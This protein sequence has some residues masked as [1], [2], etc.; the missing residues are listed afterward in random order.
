[1]QKRPFEI[2]SKTRWSKTAI[3]LLGGNGVGPAMNQFAD[4]NDMFVD[5]HNALYVADSLNHRIVKWDEDTHQA[6]IVAGGNGK[7]GQKNELNYPTAVFV[8]RQQ[9]IYVADNGNNRIQKWPLNSENGE[10]IIGQYGRGSRL[11]QID[12]CWSLYVDKRCNIYVSELSNHRITVWSPGARSGKIVVKTHSP[13]NIYVYEKTGDIYVASYAQNIIKQFAADGSLVRQIGQDFIHSP[14]GI[15]TVAD[16]LSKDV[17]VFAA[18]S[19]YHQILQI[20]IGE[21]NNTNIIAGTNNL[22][23]NQSNQFNKP[24]KVHFDSHGNMLVLD[25]NNQRIQKF[26]VE[27]NECNLLYLNIYPSQRS[28]PLTHRRVRPGWRVIPSSQGEKPP[29]EVSPPKIKDSPIGENFFPQPS[30]GVFP[31]PVDADT[32]QTSDDISSDGH[33]PLNDFSVNVPQIS[34]FRGSFRRKG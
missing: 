18:D 29:N 11:D 16:A 15:I 14:F 5:S 30:F 4:P 25:S 1:M 13:L 32:R 3:T 20:Q 24:K 9:N 26:S 7:G 27:K 33:R 23:G 22:S 8:D 12:N 31:R 19:Q 28:T 2:C 6:Y 21:H 34:S 10:T 17:Y